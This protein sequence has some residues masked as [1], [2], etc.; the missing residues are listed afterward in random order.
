MTLDRFTQQNCSESNL[1]K[2]EARRRL[3]N[4]EGKVILISPKIQDFF[5][6]M[7]CNLRIY[8][9]NP[10]EGGSLSSIFLFSLVNMCLFVC[11]SVRRLLATTKKDTDLKIGTHTP[12]DHI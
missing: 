6:G 5:S 1:E 4:S 11:V 8:Y 2:K 12:L 3:E 9:Q 10:L 7:P